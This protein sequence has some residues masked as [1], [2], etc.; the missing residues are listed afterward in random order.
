MF[1]QNIF[2]FI[3]LVLVFVVVGSL[4]SGCTPA[5]EQPSG[6][7]PFQG[8]YPPATDEV[9]PDSAVTSPP[10]PQPGEPQ[11]PVWRP[12]PEDQ[13][14]QRG[15]V[16]IDALDLLT[17]ESFPPQFKLQVKGALPTPCHQLRV[18]I[19]EP[20]DQKRIFVIIYSVVDPR[21]MC[22]D[23]LQEFDVSVTIPN[24]PSGA[25]YSVWLNGQQVGEIQW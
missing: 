4:L 12:R 24:P 22:I 25:K 2:S 1:K 23:V 19:A 7:K 15:E 10:Y 18:Q 13:T 21:T 14:L 11:K 9:P 5:Q 16:F 17:L 3:G 8:A 20:D 6:G